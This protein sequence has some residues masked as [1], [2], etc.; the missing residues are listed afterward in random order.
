VILLYPIVLAVALWISTRNA[1]TP[2]GGWRWFGNWAVA[3]ALMTFSFLTGFSIGLFILPLAAAVVLW[4]ASRTPGAADPV[5]FFA[6]LGLLLVGIGVLN[7]DAGAGWVLFGSAFGVVAL[8]TYA[9]I[10]DGKPQLR[11]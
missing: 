6:G 8:A 9:A 1:R 5:G 2:R 3:G 11:R 7:S 10:P 4:V